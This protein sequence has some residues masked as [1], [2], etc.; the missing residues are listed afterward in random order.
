MPI[1]LLFVS[2]E[3]KLT[4]KSTIQMFTEDMYL[5]FMIDY[6]NRSHKYDGG[7]EC[8]KEII[9]SP[10]QNKNYCNYYYNILNPKK[11]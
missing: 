3:K 10:F 7:G 2:T 9:N 6:K 8:N 5:I 11:L 4:H 1:V